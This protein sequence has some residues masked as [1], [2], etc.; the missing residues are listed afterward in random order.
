MVLL[1]RPDW[2]WRT[3]RRCDVTQ[4]MNAHGRPLRQ[5]HHEFQLAADCFNIAAECREIHVSLILDLGDRRLL[6]VKRNLI[7]L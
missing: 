3:H 7:R 6:D 2:L 1:G 4:M 5:F